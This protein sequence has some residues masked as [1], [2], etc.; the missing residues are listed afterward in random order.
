MRVI[1]INGG[2]GVIL[3]PFKKHLVANV[4]IR[5]IFHTKNQEQWKINFGEIPY[6]KDG[7]SFLLNAFDRDYDKPDIII[8]APDCGHS[9]ILAYSR[10][11]KLSDPRDN[12]SLQLFIESVIKLKPTVFLMENLPKLLQ[13]Y[14]VEDFI[15]VFPDYYL[16]FHNL[17]VSDL[18]N[19]QKN[20][21]R[22][23]II[24]YR[25]D[26]VVGKKEKDKVQYHFTNIYKVSRLKTC[27]QLTGD[28]YKEN[29]K[30]G[31]IREDINTVI[32][33]YAGSKLSLQAIR[34]YWQENPEK[35]RYVVTDR[36]FS[37][38]PGVYRNLS[39]SFPATARKANRQYNHLG[40]QL[41]P[42]ELA[43]IQGIPDRFKLFIDPTNKLYWIN[44]T[45][46]SVTKCP[47]YEVG[48]WFYKQCKKILK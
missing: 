39:N 20:R 28:L 27:E 48:Y 7:E 21:I 11:K 32:T 31:N 2:N 14:S 16:I 23:L 45:R 42:R 18:G 37:T 10:A 30:T 6:Y 5:S 3:Y 43:R 35:K 44:K 19:S 26:S 29:Y 33:I 12:K 47:P 34:N 22:L 40:L 24:G 4:E 38:A 8:G 41:T 13:Q 1:G 46:A 15:E 25:K 9:S 17:S 36:K